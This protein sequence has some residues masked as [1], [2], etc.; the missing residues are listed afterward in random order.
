MIV[1]H[2]ADWHLGD[3]LGRIDRTE[4][5]RKG[6]ERVASLCEEHTVDVLLV[7]GDLFSERTGP[8]RMRGTIDHLSVTFAPFLARGGTI[9]AITGN[10]DNE[11]YCRMLQ[12]SMALAAPT[13]VRPGSRLERG[14]LHLSMAPGFHRLASPRGHDVQFVFMPYPTPARY[15]D[16]RRLPA[17]FPEQSRE[18]R[19]AF[20]SKLKQILEHDDF[21][22]DLP[23]VLSAHVH[24]DSVPFRLGFRISESEEVPI[25]MSDLGSFWTYAALGHIHQPQAV[26]GHPHI[27]YCGSLDRLDL[28]EREDRK[29][30]VLFEIGPKGLTGAPRSIPLDATPLAEVVIRDPVKDIPALRERYP[31]AERTIASLRLTYRPGIDVPHQVREEV[32][33]I[34]PRW[35]Q[36]TLE[37]ESPELGGLQ[38]EGIESAGRSVRETVLSYLDEQLPKEQPDRAEILQLAGDYLAPEV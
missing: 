14:R 7:A 35:Y 4:D 31:E 22:A 34:F 6:V 18:L 33:T 29:E 21:R 3:T 8:E 12:A 10:H 9:L 24:V 28:G 23:S 38:V 25:P 19:H 5:L 37:A 32:E 27:R 16:G 2:T 20:I 13:I 1:L 17:S 36:S 15:L 30:V 26:S 11:T